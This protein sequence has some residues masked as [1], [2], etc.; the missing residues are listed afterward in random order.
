MKMAVYKWLAFCL[1]GATSQLAFVF[2]ANAAEVRS[3]GQGNPLDNLPKIDAAP[4]QAVSVEIQSQQQD[5]AMRALLASRITPSGFQISGVETLPFALVAAEFSGFVGREVTV[6]EILNAAQRV[7]QIYQ[8]KGYPLSFA[9]VPA[10]SF[11]KNI[12]VI[13]VVEG[14][15]ASIKV[16]GN[17]C[18][19]VSPS[20]N[21]TFPIW[22]SAV[23]STR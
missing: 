16:Q 17:T 13:N 4:A 14:Y 3:P 18:T 1:T 5:P 7:T 10:Q 2:L 19:T 23:K 20:L 12:V 9:F 21:C 8:D 6:A 22:N 11:E 15:V